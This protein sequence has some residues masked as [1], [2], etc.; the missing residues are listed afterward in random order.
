[1]RIIASAL[2]LVVVATAV[3]G[4]EVYRST[5][6][7]GNVIYSDRPQDA[8]SEYVYIATPRSSA[9]RAPASSEPQ[10]GAARQAA[11]A[12]PAPEVVPAPRSA[13]DIAQQRAQNCNVAR[14]RV[15]SY[16]ASHRLYRQLP[17]GEREYLS[18]DQLDEAR[19]RAAADVE[20]WC[21]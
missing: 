9:A 15:Q 17:N 16:T 12:P 20:T 18:D 3:Q 1:M 10:A 8:R 21:S 11:A 6:A 14:Q 2:A 4:A 5:D 13:E 7:N 19:A